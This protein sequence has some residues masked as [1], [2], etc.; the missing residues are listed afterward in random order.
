MQARGGGMSSAIHYCRNCSNRVHAIG[1]LCVA[2]RPREVT[3]KVRKSHALPKGDWVLDPVRR[4][5]A[6]RE[7]PQK[8]KKLAS[9][10]AKHR[11]DWYNL[12]D[13]PKCGVK[14]G[15]PC[16]SDGRTVPAHK[17]RYDPPK[18]IECDIDITGGSH[19][20]HC[21]PCYVDHRRGQYRSKSERFRQTQ[22][23]EAA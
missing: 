12:G 21:E 8:P 20:N 5:L 4:V 23:E 13:C 11:R 9:P 14:A 3:I 7:A 1:M 17:A 15:E 6:Y 2:C 18:C 16:L 19:R 22:S 10:T